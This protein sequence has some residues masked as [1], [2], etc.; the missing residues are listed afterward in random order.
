[1]A[2]FLPAKYSRSAFPRLSAFTMFKTIR[3]LRPVTR[4]QPVFNSRWLNISAVSVERDVYLEMLDGSS[5]GIA[6]LNLNRPKAK[7]AI[8][9]KFLQEFREA[10][11]EARFSRYAN[12]TV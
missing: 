11:K 8:S 1:M 2:V 10:L 5:K 12:G 9:V 6:V 3:L 4:I 7:N